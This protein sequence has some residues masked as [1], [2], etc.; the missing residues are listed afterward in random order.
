MRTALLVALC[1]AAYGLPARADDAEEEPAAEEAAPAPKPDAIDAAGTRGP[2]AAGVTTDRG[3]RPKF[4][5]SRPASGRGGG[6]GGGARARVRSRRS[7]P[8]MPAPRPWA[9]R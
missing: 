1:L 7:G 5:G 9:S 8:K 6:G 3:A 2:A 4:N